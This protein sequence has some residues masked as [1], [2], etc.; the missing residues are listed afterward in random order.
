MLLN[1]RPCGFGFS[2]VNLLPLGSPLLPLLCNMVEVQHLCNHMG[3]DWWKE[4]HLIHQG[5]IKENNI[6]PN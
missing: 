1:L 6:M 2:Q 4:Y 3:H 5:L